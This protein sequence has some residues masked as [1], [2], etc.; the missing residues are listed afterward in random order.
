MTHFHGCQT[1]DGVQRRQTRRTRF[2]YRATAPLLAPVM[3]AFEHALAARAVDEFHHAV[4]RLPAG[5][6]LDVGT[7]TGRQLTLFDERSAAGA[8]GL[9]PVE[10]LLRRL[11]Q[12][13]PETAAVVGDAHHLPFAPAAYDAAI[14]AWVW[15]T[16][17][18]PV[19]AA[20]E[21]HRTLRPGGLLLSIACTRP[22]DRPSVG[23]GLLDAAFLGLFGATVDEA[24]LTDVSGF[25]A[26]ENHRFNRG[27]FSVV[28]L[29]RG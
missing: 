5:R 24:V 2:A 26:L 4:R 7:G 3:H 14:A 27:L 9:D 15:E 21:L 18:D 16:L 25:T 1:S 20:R 10:P 17:T 23:A 28:L 19:A 6:I 8:V 13:L 29:R 12:R 11:R 22:S